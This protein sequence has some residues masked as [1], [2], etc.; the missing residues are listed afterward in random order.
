MLLQIRPDH[1]MLHWWVDRNLQYTQTQTAMKLT[2]MHGLSWI[3]TSM[4]LSSCLCTIYYTGDLTSL[5]L[6]DLDGRTSREHHIPIGMLGSA[7]TMLV[8]L[9]G[10]NLLR[11]VPSMTLI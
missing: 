11:G 8:T 4:L 6:K 10:F 7:S 9:V 1:A 2:N 3:H 5:D